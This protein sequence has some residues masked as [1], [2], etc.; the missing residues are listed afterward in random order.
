[1]NMIRQ[2]ILQIR[3]DIGLSWE[4][5]AEQSSRSIETLKKQI[6]EDANPTLATVVSIL[7]PLHA[8]LEVMTDADKEQLAQA[9]ILR[10]RVDALEKLLADARSDRDKLGGQISDLTK[11]NETMAMQMEQQQKIITRLE[12]MI[13]RKEEIVQKK[14]AALERKDAV[15][16]ELLRKSGAI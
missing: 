1:M 4:S 11:A 13:D 12:T 6:S 8:T 9:D 2:K 10:E 15:I 14:D 3:K 7:A 16:G 5:W